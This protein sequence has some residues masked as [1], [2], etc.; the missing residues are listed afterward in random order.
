MININELYLKYYIKAYI[1]DNFDNKTSFIIFQND[2]NVY[3]INISFKHIVEY[4]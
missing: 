1:V 2:L 4:I 3:F